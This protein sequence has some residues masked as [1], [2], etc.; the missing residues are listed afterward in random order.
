MNGPPNEEAAIKLQLLEKYMSREPKQFLQF[1]GFTNI[2]GDCQV[3]PDENGDSFSGS[4]TTELMHGSDVR[5]M[6]IPGTTRDEA[7][8]L[9][10]KIRA[11]VKSYPPGTLLTAPSHDA[12][13]NE[14]GGPRPTN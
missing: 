8:R 2:E 7:L 4:V 6:V 12:E 5:V 14:L 9:L 10:K 3:R 13:A 1:D 11:C